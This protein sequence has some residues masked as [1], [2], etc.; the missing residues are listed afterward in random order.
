MALTVREYLTADGKSPFREWLDSLTVAVRARIQARVL[1]FELGNLG[2]NKSIG[3]GVSGS[4]RDVRPWVPDLFRQG[5]RLDHRASG[6]R[7]QGIP[8]EG[9]FAR[10]R[11]LARLSGGQTPW[12]GE[13]EIGMLGWRRIFG[14]RHSL[15]SSCWP[16]STK[17]CRSKSRLQRLFEPWALRSSRQRF[18]WPARTYCEP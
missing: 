2:D 8:V 11:S 14:I 1:R 6:R 10:A 13:V 9:H 4:S 7:R 18:T 17:A 12:Q 16:R 3:S 5:R 15:E